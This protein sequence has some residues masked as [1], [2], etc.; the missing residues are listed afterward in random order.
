MTT[1]SDPTNAA[2]LRTLRARDHFSLSAYWLAT[3]VLWGAWLM[4]VLPSQMKQIAPE[5]PAETQGMMLG[6][7]TIPAL[8]VPLL[9]G[10]LSDRC[11][12]GWG[13]RRPYMVAG[14]VINILGLF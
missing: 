14:V 12:S 8:V 13:R 6:W 11:T 5:S 4:I 7:G 1:A 9:V 2:P 3:N 10:A